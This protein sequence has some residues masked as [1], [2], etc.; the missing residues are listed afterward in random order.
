MKLHIFT[1]V[2]AAFILNSCGSTKNKENLDSIDSTFPQIPSETFWELQTL[3]GKDFSSFTN[4]N[5]KVGFTLDNEDNRISGFAGCNTFFGTYTFEP[6]NRI[7]FSALGATRMACPD[8]A[9]NENEFLKIF[10][11]ADNYTLDGNTLSLNVGRRAPLAIFK[12]VEKSTTSITETYWKLKILEGKDVQMAKNQER[13]V[14]FILKSK[15]NQVTGFGGCN[16]LTGTY[17]LAEGNRINFSEM[18]ATLMA[19]PDVDFNESEFLKIF[20][21]ADNYQITGDR[22]ELNVGRRAPLAIFEAVY[23]D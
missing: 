11:L 17:S 19:C 13:E 3:E 23:L 21:L 12:K 20:E 2:L 6:G 8:I 5:K 10:E 15:D 18:G 7:S 9:F 16:S 22:L 1:L 4:N 14:F